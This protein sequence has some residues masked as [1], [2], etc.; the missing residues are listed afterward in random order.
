M[1]SQS[2]STVALRGS[3]NARIIVSFAFLLFFYLPLPMSNAYA[4]I[5]VDV[6]RQWSVLEWQ[7]NEIIAP[8][9]EKHVAIKRGTNT[10]FFV[11]YNIAVGEFFAILADA[12]DMAS[13]DPKYEP[14]ATRTLA[15]NEVWAL[16]AIPEPTGAVLI[17]VN[18]S[19]FPARL[20][21][22]LV[23][24]GT[25]SEKATTDMREML[26]FPIRDF[27]RQY[28]VPPLTAL[29]PFPKRSNASQPLQKS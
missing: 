19:P 14:L 23:Q 17:V 18:N 20:S 13:K 6:S 5:R 25:A 7:V 4:Q 10:R 16:P 12:R 15:R 1:D 9:Q 29:W 22:V 26:E 28:N 3:L 27:T 2:R 11:K 21:L 8:G 24:S